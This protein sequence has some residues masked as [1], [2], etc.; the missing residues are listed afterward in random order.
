M[1]RFDDLLEGSRGER[2]TMR[3]LRSNNKKFDRAPKGPAGRSDRRAAVASSSSATAKLHARRAHRAPAGARGWY[4]PDKHE[5]ISR[6]D[7][8]AGLNEDHDPADGVTL[9]ELHTKLV[10]AVAACKSAKSM[11]ECVKHCSEAEAALAG[12]KTVVDRL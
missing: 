1:G 10:S 9:R 5:N 11:E 8:A 3:M 12:M 7:A 6:F 4:T 2:R